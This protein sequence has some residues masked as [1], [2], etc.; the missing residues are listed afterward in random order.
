MNSK[1]I[2]EFLRIIDGC[3]VAELNALRDRISSVIQLRLDQASRDIAIEGA[4]K[5]KQV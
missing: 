5:R 4:G 2:N 1:D 3:E